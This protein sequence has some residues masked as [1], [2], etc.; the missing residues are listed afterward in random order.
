MMTGGGGGGGVYDDRHWLENEGSPKS[1][2]ANAY[3]RNENI[4]SQLDFTSFEVRKKKR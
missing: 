2:I 1:R 3:F 4:I